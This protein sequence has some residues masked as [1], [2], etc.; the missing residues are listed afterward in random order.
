ML[1]SS[2]SAIPSSILV[3]KEGYLLKQG[4]VVKNWKQRWFRFSDGHIQYSKA[5]NEASIGEIILGSGNVRLIHDPVDILLILSAP[6]SISSGDQQEESF[7]AV[8]G[9]KLKNDNIRAEGCFV[10]IDATGK[11]FLLYASTKEEKDSWINA[12]KA[13][14]DV[15]LPVGRRSPHKIHHEKNLIFRQ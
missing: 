3:H 11:Q 7:Q 12:L 10:I 14:L 15:K 6:T 4:H 5:P 1:K 8:Q 13:R 2:Y 9:L